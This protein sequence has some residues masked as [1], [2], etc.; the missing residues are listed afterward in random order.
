MNQLLAGLH[1][2][3]IGRELLAGVTLIAIAIPLNIGYAQIAGLPATA[4]LYALIVPTLIWAFMTSSRQLV[5]SPD[6]AVAALVASS[7]RRPRSS[8]L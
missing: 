5:V 4:G 1:R 3:N 8:R 2:R 6:A 7:L